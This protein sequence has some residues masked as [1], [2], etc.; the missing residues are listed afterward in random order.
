MYNSYNNKLYRHVEGVEENALSL[1]SALDWYERWK[2]RPGRF[3]PRK[4]APVL[5][6]EKSWSLIE[7]AHKISN[8]RTFEPKTFQPVASLI[9]EWA[10]SVLV[11]PSS[12]VNM[13]WC[14]QGSLFNIIHLSWRLSR[15]V[16]LIVSKY[17]QCYTASLRKTQ[18]SGHHGAF[19]EI[20]FSPLKNIDSFQCICFL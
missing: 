9:T 19:H 4:S 5:I 6:A 20:T 18:R 13:R 16:R 17:L 7:C 10:I 15:Q 12:L 3:T 2:S 1:T 11:T 8:P 14:L